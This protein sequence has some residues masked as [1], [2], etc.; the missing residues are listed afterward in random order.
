[1]AFLT[2]LATLPQESL[3]PIS[4]SETGLNVVAGPWLEHSSIRQLFCTE[5]HE[6]KNKLSFRGRRQ[7]PSLR[8]LR[9]L[10]Q[11]DSL[12]LQNRRGAAFLC[13]VFLGDLSVRQSLTCR[14]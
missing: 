11:K 3:C 4:F 8:L 1:M 6:V 7:F 14:S 10:F 5:G 12:G 9:C 13:I 2:S